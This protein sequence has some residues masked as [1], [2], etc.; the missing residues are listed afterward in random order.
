LDEGEEPWKAHAVSG[1]PNGGETA[2]GNF[3]C[4]PAA[5]RRPVGVKCAVT[6]VSP[7]PKAP[8]PRE[9]QAHLTQADSMTQTVAGRHKIERSDRCWA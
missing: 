1:T 6:T 9:R 5:L 8:A 7:A 3:C 4:K 2:I